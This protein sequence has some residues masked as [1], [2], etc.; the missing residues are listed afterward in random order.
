M[1]I[2]NHFQINFKGDDIRYVCTIKDLNDLTSQLLKITSDEKDEFIFIHQSIQEYLGKEIKLDDFI[3]NHFEKNQ[4]NE[5]SETLQLNIPNHTS[6]RLTRFF[7]YHFINWN[8]LTFEDFINGIIIKNKDLFFLD[9][10]PQTKYGIYIKIGRIIRR[11][12]ASPYYDIQPR[13]NITKDLRID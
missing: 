6:N 10:V 9:N 1:E 4:F 7:N 3:F 11:K 2:E 13:A 5:L 8:E 12:I